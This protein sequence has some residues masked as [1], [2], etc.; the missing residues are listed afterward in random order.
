M[1]GSVSR[2]RRSREE[3]R[4]LVEE[5]RESGLSRAEFAEKSG[6]HQN[7]VSLW[8]RRGQEDDE[9]HGLV[10]VRLRD[11]A[12]PRDSGVEVALRDGL[13]IR[14]RRGFDRE[15]LIEALAALDGSC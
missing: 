7:T 11:A 4:C 1:R 5:F 15:V 2:R 3:V 10:P 6:V 14:L 12:P 13:T 8:L 9:P